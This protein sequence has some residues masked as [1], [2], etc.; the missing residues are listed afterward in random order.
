MGD[1]KDPVDP[2]QEGSAEGAQDASSKKVRTDLKNWL[3]NAPRGWNTSQK[4]RSHD[5]N[6]S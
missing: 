5:S 6:E 1:E 2:P 3:A 4:R